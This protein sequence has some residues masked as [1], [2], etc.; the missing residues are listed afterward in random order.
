MKRIVNKNGTDKS[1]A[2]PEIATM[3]EV[4]TLRHK[5]I[6][7]HFYR[8]PDG[9]TLEYEVGGRNEMP[10]SDDGITEFFKIY[11]KM[12][13]DDDVDRKEG[14]IP[15]WEAKFSVLYMDEDLLNKHLQRNYLPYVMQRLREYAA[16]LAESEV[17]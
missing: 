13:E 6:T 7:V 11:T 4:S 5:E 8:L 9:N 12:C 10:I 1:G 17:Q 14:F 15:S 3:L 16:N 2:L